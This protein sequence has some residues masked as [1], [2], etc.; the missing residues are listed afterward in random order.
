[1]IE[2]GTVSQGDVAAQAAA[3]AAT[4]NNNSYDLASN[5]TRYPLPGTTRTRCS[6]HPLADLATRYPALASD[7][8]Y[9]LPVNPHPWPRTTRTL[10]GTSVHT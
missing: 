4:R 5:T 1:M 7:A 6:L 2:N 3:Q 10:R 8:R 9:S